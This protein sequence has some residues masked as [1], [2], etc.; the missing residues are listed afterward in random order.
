MPELKK[1]ESIKKASNETENQAALRLIREVGLKNN[2]RISEDDLCAVVAAFYP[3][4]CQ[5]KL[6]STPEQQILENL[7]YY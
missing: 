6:R 4:E 1:A 7:L 3:E 2:Q 5:T